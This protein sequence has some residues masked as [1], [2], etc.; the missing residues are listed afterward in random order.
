MLYMYSNVLRKKNEVSVM[1][2]AREWPRWPKPPQIPSK[3]KK[4]YKVKQLLLF[5]AFTL[6]IKLLHSELQW[7]KNALNV[8]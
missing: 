2:V 5:T 1:G 7:R 4:I 6:H 8:L 3:K